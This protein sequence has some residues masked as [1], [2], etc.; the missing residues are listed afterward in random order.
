MR[1]RIAAN[2]LSLFCAWILWEKSIA[3]NS[4]PEIH[5][6]WEGKSLDECRKAAPDFAGKKKEELEMMF[7]DRAKFKV[8]RSTTSAYV[9]STETSF[10]TTVNY[11]CLPSSV[12][13]YYDPRQRD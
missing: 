4:N 9:T 10:R 12:S 11:E 8:G 3:P 6:M 1:V 2:L 13:P 7:G 5:A